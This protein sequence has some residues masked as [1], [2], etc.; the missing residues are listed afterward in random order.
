L[1]FGADASEELVAV[2]DIGGGFDDADFLAAL[3]VVE[4]DLKELHGFAAAHGAVA[5]K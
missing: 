3:F 4:G 5:K 1:A 2:F